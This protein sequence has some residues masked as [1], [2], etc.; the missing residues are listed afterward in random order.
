ME[1]R[2]LRCFLAVADELHFARAAE[3]LHIEQSPLSRAIKE[4]EADLGVQLFARTT[5][6]TRLTHAGKLFLENVPRIFTALEQARDSVRAAANG[7]RNQLRVAISDCVVPSEFSAFLALCRQ[8]EPEIEIRLFEVP[9]SQQIKG[10]HEDLYDVGFARSNEVGDGIIAEVAWTDPLMVA[11]PARHPLLAYKRIPLEEVLRYPLVLGDPHVCEGCA[12]QVERVLRQVDQEPLIAERVASIDL[13]MALVAAGFAL[14]LAGASHI[15]VNRESRVV[16]RPL[17]GRVP[18]LTTYLL[19][20][21]NDPA[22]ALIRFIA[23][24]GSVKAPPKGADVRSFGSNASEDI[25][26]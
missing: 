2:H 25:E 4:L 8:E 21:D 7:F 6:S 18:M 16:A 11:V 1:L 22:D 14:G 5:R 3:R 23:R 19:R 24:A 15:T 26:P 13:M 10:L 17:A 20:L 9:L 12:R